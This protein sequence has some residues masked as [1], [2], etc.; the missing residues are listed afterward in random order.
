MENI[1]LKEL[2]LLYILVSSVVFFVVFSSPSVYKIT[3]EKFEKYGI[4]VSDENGCPYSY[5]ILIH[6]VL[7]V[8]VLSALFSRSY[9][10]GISVILL[11]LFLMLVV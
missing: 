6:S 10:Y 1:Q 9:I 7:F 3:N 8:L 4:T 11:L 5:G 2:N